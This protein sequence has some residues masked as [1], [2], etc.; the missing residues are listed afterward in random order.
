MQPHDGLGDT[1]RDTEIL[2][3]VDRQRQ[4]FVALVWNQEVRLVVSVLLQ[5]VYQS[6]QGVVLVGGVLQCPEFVE[7]MLQIRGADRLEQVIH[8]VDLE[9]PQRI[10][11]V[12]RSKYYRA[13]DTYM[14]EYL[15]RRA[16]SQMYVHEYHIGRGVRL[17]PCD[18][19]GDAVQHLRNLNVGRNILKQ[20]LQIAH[21]GLLILNYKCFHSR[22]A[23]VAVAAER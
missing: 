9:C 7:G 20:S 5:G 15:E 12:C 17:E 14:L 1:L 18:A 3:L 23:V 21:C 2:Y 13:V 6:R 4:Q 10:F 11:V 8:T 19:V 22:F 16:V